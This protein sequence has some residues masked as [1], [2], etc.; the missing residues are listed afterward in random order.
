MEKKKLN[1]KPIKQMCSVPGCANRGSYT[2]A[3]T[4]YFGGVNICEDCLREAMAVIE[5]IEPNTPPR[6]EKLL[7]DDTFKEEFKRAIEDGI[8]EG[9]D[10][11]G[12]TVTDD[13]VTPDGYVPDTDNQENNSTTDTAEPIE[14]GVTPDSD[15]AANADNSVRENGENLIPDKQFVCDKCGKVC[16]NQSGLASHKKACD[17]K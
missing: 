1:V 5:P 6:L 15:E 9:L 13:S 4:R 16:A 3:R 2:I 14:D 8:K 17:D 7:L 12:I 10:K 11:A